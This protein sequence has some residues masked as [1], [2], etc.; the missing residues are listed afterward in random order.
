MLQFLYEDDSIILINK[1]PGIPSQ[2]D[3]TG[4]A[5][6]LELAQS[7]VKGDL[8]IINRLDRPASGIVLLA[9]GSQVAAILFDSWRSANTKKI[10]LAAVAKKKLDS[11][12]KLEHFLF[13]DGRKNKSYVTDASHPKSKKCVLD[14]KKLSETENYMILQI[15]LQTGRHHQIRVQLAAI[16]IPVKGDVKYGFRRSNKDRSIHLHAWKIS[17]VHPVTGKSLN[18]VAPLPNDPIWDTIIENP[19]S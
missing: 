13:K 1:Q 7:K 15:V 9:K 4:D 17:F 2:P 16:G 8:H 19:V 3:K 5:S 10:Y 18:F 14:Y 6:I 11:E 12:G